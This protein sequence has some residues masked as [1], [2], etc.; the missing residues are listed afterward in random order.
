[1]ASAAGGCAGR[2]LEPAT[3]ATVAMLFGDPTNPDLADSEN[4]D[5]H[6][7]TM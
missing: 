6:I 7:V 5:M 3:T 2:K 1:M 4:A